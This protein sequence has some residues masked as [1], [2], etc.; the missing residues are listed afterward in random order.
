MKNIQAFPS[1]RGESTEPDDGMTL[2]DYFAG[3]VL[4]SDIK[5]SNYT[6]IA[7]HCYNIAEEMVE[8]KERRDK[9]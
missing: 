8:E 2:L 4:S 6:N 5:F 9:K 3:Q 1:F 7:T